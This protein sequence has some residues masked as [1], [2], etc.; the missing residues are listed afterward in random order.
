MRFQSRKSSCG[1]S[2]LSNALEARGLKRTEDELAELCKQSAEGT[3]PENLRR[4]VAAVGG[5]NREIHESREDVA[6]LY[7]LHALEDG[8]PVI[9]CVTANGKPWEHWVVAIG[10]LGHKRVIVVDSGDN[11]L[12]VTKKF[13]DLVEWWRGPAGAKR[14]F[15]GVI[16]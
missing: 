11:D 3:S 2:A 8:H 10:T 16:V 12:V 1:P 4:A 13:D 15:Y 14:Q 5:V 9:L 7:L 6:L